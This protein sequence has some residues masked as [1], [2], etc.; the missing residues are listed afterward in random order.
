[1][2]G[3]CSFDRTLC[4]WRNDTLHVNGKAVNVNSH[5]Q[6]DSLRSSKSSLIS[7]KISH[8]SGGV[9]GLVGS[10]HL[11]HH[12]NQPGSSLI[13]NDRSFALSGSKPLVSWRLATINS[14]PANLQDHTFR[15]PGMHLIN[16]H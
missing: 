13:A 15:A 3:E 4:G 11:S 5:G 6:L 10:S 8:T 12:H 9:A 16:L 2:D 14:R 1:M 7:H